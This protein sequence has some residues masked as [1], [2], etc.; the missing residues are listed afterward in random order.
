MGVQKTVTKPG[1]G[2]TPKKGQRITVH[3]TGTIESTGL[4]SLLWARA[5]SDESTGKKFWS[6]K[7]PGQQPFSFEVGLGKVIRGMFHGCL[8]QRFTR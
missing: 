5:I 2:V 8:N 6:T 3:C 4:S 1:N 7:D